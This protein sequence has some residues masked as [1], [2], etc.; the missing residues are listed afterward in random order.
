MSTRRRP[1]L[2]LAASAAASGSAA[3]YSIGFWLFL[4]AAGPIHEDVRMTYV[5]AQAGLRYGWASIYDEA[6]LRSLSAAFPAGARLIDPLYTYLNPPLLAWL[7]APLTAFSEPVAYALWTL[8]SLVAL[9]LAWRIAAP[10]SGLAKITLL[11]LAA[12]LWPV[13]LAFYFG[14]PTMLLLLLMAGAW[15]LVTHDRPLAAGAVLAVATFLKPQDIILIPIVLLVSGRY[16]PVVGWLIG[17]AVLGVATLAALQPS[18]LAIWFQALQHGQASPAHVE[19]TLA[20]FF[21]LGPLTYLLWTVQCAAAIAVAWW[22][23]ADPEMVFVAGILGTAAVAFHFHELD[24]S[25]LLLAAWLFLRTSPPVWQRLWLLAGIVTMQVM[26][27]GPQQTQPVWD[28][29]T[30]A[31]QL[32]WD[33]AWLAILVAGSFGEREVTARKKVEIRVTS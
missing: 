4:F 20:H 1:P 31:P 16:R 9:V 30:H 5:A 22:R 14:Q 27:F 6:T 26:T 28:I 33:A 15:W 17:C 18:G 29:A 10:Y 11:L 32:I 12:G 8:V 21:G 2:W 3:A 24:Y 23:R 25:I 19:Y 7:F 13:L